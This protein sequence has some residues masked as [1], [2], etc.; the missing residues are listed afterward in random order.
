[1]NKLFDINY[2]MVKPLAFKLRPNS[3][4]EFIGQE[5]VIGKNSMLY[6]L[7]KRKKLIN[8]V[9]YGPPGVGKTSL[10]ELLSN[11]LNYSFEKLNA[12]TANLSDFKEVIA[13]AKKR[14]EYEEVKTILFLDEIHRFN[15][16]QQDA[17]LPYTEEGIITLIGATTENPYYS[18]N[19]ALISRLMVFEFKKFNN[20]DIK[21]LINRAISI[22]EINLDEEIISY[23]LELSSGDGRVIINY[24]EIIN[25]LELFSLDEVKEVFDKRKESFHKKEDKYNIISAMIKSI[26]GSDPHS[27]VYW[28]GRLLEGGED[29]RYVAR[30]LVISASEDIGLANPEA[31]LIANS[32]LIAS[33]RIGMPEVQIILSEAIIYLAISSK[34][35]SSYEAINSVLTDIANGNREEVPYYLTD[36]GSKDYKYPHSYPNNF[37]SQDYMKQSKKYYEA[38]NNKNEKLIEKK[39]KD[40]WKN[41]YY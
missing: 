16:L 13:R 2:D 37:V 5:E 38:G 32:A 7:I 29:P 3:L 15:K 31:M 4:S 21:K 14:I 36:L 40:L 27:A 26:R 41:R 20:R 12:T 23:L 1:M 24:L 11:E 10:A 35:S 28:M 17:L 25:E 6:K 34:S 18:L 9:F 8:C 19:N 22:L 39:L 33:E 30:R